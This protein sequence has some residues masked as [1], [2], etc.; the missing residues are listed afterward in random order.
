MNHAWL[1]VASCDASCV[2]DDPV[3]MTG[4][5]VRILRGSGRI[6]ALLAVLPLMP[7]TAIPHPKQYWGVR[8]YSRLLLR[9]VGV[10]ITVSGNQLRNIS[11]QL[12]VS[13]HIS[14]IDVLAIWGV[15]PSLFVAKA[16]MVKWPGIGQMARALGVVPIDRTKLRPLPG[17]VA[18]LTERMKA[19]QTVATFPEGTSWCGIGRGRFRPAMFQAAINA[20]KPVQPLRLRYEH[21]DGRLSTVPAFVGDDGLVP[22]IWRV[23]ATK[24]TVVNIHVCDL[25]LPGTDRRELARRCQDVVW[26]KIDMSCDE[27][28][29]DLNVP[30]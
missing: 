12:V 16:D 5:I 22:S 6:A 19:G 8:T 26:G 29:I 4:R 21:A 17:I 13:P 2:R 14:W 9:C 1:P 25:Q 24:S 23:A 27:H 30:A 11:G 18:E 3:R 20:N 10:R 15:M 7:L 28:E